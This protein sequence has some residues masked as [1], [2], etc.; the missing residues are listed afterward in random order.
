MQ[1]GVGLV[2][3][4]SVPQSLIRIVSFVMCILFS[5]LNKVDQP[6]AAEDQRLTTTNNL[7]P[8]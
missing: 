8:N 7:R 5:F 1:P 6:D 4:I 2:S 3:A